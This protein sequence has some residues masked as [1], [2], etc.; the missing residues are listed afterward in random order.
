[1]APAGSRYAREAELVDA[2]APYNGKAVLAFGGI[3]SA[4]KA[5]LEAGYIRRIEELIHGAVF[6]DFLDMATEL[7]TKGYKDAAVVIAGS[8]LE[9][10]VRKLVARAG[11]ALTDENGRQYS[12]DALAIALVKSERFSEPQRKLLVGWYAQRTAGAHGRYEDVI[13]AEVP[14]MIDGIRDFMVRFPA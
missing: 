12:F 4:L 8:V 3:L 14:R 13:E 7:R 6:E 5:D 10:H 2:A 11:L 1:L 9:E